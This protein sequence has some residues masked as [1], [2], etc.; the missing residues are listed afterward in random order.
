MP[1]LALLLVLLGVGAILAT[2]IL[3]LGDASV[4]GRVPALM[5]AGLAGFGGLSLV[6]GLW[7]LEQRP[8]GLNR[9]A[10]QPTGHKLL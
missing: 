3:V 5:V 2:V 6:V 4:P 9:G 10:V 7:R 8:I 1:R